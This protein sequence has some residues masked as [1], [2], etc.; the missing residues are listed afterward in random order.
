MAWIRC[1]ALV[2]RGRVRVRVWIRVR[3]R[4]GVG[5]CLDLCIRHS[6]TCK[7][8][9]TRTRLYHG[10][11]NVSAIHIIDRLCNDTRSEQNTLVTSPPS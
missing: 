4:V 5:V 7:K 11:G 2:E 9:L 8:G 1:G 3:F 6:T 10:K